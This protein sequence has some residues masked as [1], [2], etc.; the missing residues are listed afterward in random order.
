MRYF[1]FCIVQ[2]SQLAAKVI[3]NDLLTYLLSVIV[4]I[5]IGVC[6][7]DSSFCFVLIM[8]YVLL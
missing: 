1:L 7:E 8:L 6:S 2:S 4:A 5:M 3:T